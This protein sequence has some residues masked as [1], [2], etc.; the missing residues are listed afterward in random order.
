VGH[1]SRS[2]GLLHLEATRA[3][4]SES[5]LKTSGGAACMVLVA[6]SW[7]LCRGQVED[8]WADVMSY[9]RPCYH[10]F[11]VFFVFGPGG[12]LVI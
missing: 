7:R 9:V 12:I 6:S 5:S 2:N 11:A 10:C 1:A 3:R 4:V 8:G